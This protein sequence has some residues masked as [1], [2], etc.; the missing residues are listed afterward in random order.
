VE[1]VDERLVP[2]VVGVLREHAVLARGE[3]LVLEGCGAHRVG[4]VVV[5]RDD[6]EGVLGEE[7]LEHC[8]R[9]LELDDHRRGVGLLGAVEVDD[10]RERHSGGGGLG[11][12][13][14]P[15]GEQDVLGGDVLAVVE[16]DALAELDRPRLRVGRGLHRLG[17]RGGDP[18]VVVPDQQRLVEVEAARD[19]RVGHGPVRVERV[20]AAAAGGAVDEDAAALLR[21][22][23]AAAP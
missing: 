8:V 6:A 10:R 1:L 12:G 19:V 3:R 2:P 9:R 7:V 22:A 23:T 13:D 4:R 15:E 11:A 16:G 18:V 5:G 21:T 17:E 14:P 20:R